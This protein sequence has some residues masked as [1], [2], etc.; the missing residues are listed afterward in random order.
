VAWDPPVG[1]AWPEVAAALEAA[2]GSFDEIAGYMRM[3]VF[4]PGMALLLLR[5][6]KPLAFVKLRHGDSSAL[7]HEARALAAVSSY[8]PCSFQVPAVQCVGGVA[9]WHF[10]AVSPL[11]AQL[12]RT[13]RKPPLDKILEEVQAALASTP[14]PPQVPAAWRPMHGDFAPWNLRR[15]GVDSL[16]LVDWESAGWG[17]PDADEAFYLATVA[18]LSDRPA[19]RRVSPESARFWR[20]QM[21][22]RPCNARDRRLT[23]ALRRVL[24]RMS[25]DGNG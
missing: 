9:G 12:H 25:E 3:Q 23:I 10:L 2:L 8:G 13:P 21:V 15:T 11:P 5:H 14:R 1:G 4:R 18:A 20:D 6:G 16:F 17:P 22:E 24:E 19:P 7:C